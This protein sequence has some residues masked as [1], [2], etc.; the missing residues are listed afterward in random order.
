ASS[1]AILDV[2]VGEPGYDV[3]RP[4]V[5]PPPGEVKELTLV[6]TPDTFKAGKRVKL[7]FRVTWDTRPVAGARIRVGRTHLT[8]DKN[9]RAA[10]F[11]TIRR[12][13]KH[14]ASVRKAGYR[15]AHADILTRR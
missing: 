7:R 11:V 14:R 12:P 6:V 2:N 8:S 4:D 15:P 9:G 1:F 5:P 3:L 10:G 13:G